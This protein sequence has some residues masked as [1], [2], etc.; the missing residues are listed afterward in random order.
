M[1]LQVN[2]E[3]FTTD[4]KNIAQLVDAAQGDDDGC[5]VAV[6]GEVIPR[7]KWEE[8]TLEDGAS[9]DILTAVQGG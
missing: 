8:T 7:S 5:A 4:A 1:I 6:D 2:G 3:E 9:I